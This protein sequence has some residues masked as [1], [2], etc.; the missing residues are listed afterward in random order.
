MHMSA[1]FCICICTCIRKSICIGTCTWYLH[2][3]F[4]C[5]CNCKCICTCTQTVCRIAVWMPT[6]RFAWLRVGQ[7]WRACRLNQLSTAVHSIWK[8]RCLYVRE[9]AER[10]WKLALLGHTHS[11]AQFGPNVHPLCTYLRLGEV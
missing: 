11:S 4:K 1:C 9:D 7:S 6:W 10:A 2:S 5:M 8:G 3:F